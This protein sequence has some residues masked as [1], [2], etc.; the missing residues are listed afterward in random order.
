MLFACFT[1][2]PVDHIAQLIAGSVHDP[3]G[4]AAQDPGQ[5]FAM[6]PWYMSAAGYPVVET[7]ARHIQGF[8]QL[9][10]MFHFH[11]RIPLR[12]VLV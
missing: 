1:Q 2:M 3:G 9:A 5:F 6:A 10:V 7:G 12:F 11:S 8:S 4:V